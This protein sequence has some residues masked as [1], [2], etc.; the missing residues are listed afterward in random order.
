MP[1]RSC[2][3]RVINDEHNR[4]ITVGLP[5]RED[6]A[7]LRHS[8]PTVFHQTFSGEICLLIVDERGDGAVGEMAGGLAA[9]YGRVEV[10]ANQ[11]TGSR[12]ASCNRIL[13]AARGSHIAWITPGV[14][15]HPEK[16]ALQL[17]AL[18][19][20]DESAAPAICTNPF[21][22]AW[23]H[24]DADEH[25]L[26]RVAGDQRYNIAAE[27]LQ[28][29]LST[30]LGSVEVFQAAGGF[31]EN[32]DAREDHEFALRFVRS[33]GQFVNT[34]GTRALC[35]LPRAECQDLPS[36]VAL[37]NKAIWQRH[38]PVYR[39]YGWRFALEAKARH[40]W[41]TARCCR[42]NRSRYTRWMYMVRAAM[43]DLASGAAPV[44]A[45]QSALKA[46]RCAGHCVPGFVGR[47]AR[48]SAARLL[49][50]LS[51]VVA[52]TRHLGL[53][54]L[55]GWLGLAPLLDRP[56]LK[57]YF[58]RAMIAAGPDSAGFRSLYGRR[59]RN[60]GPITEA[61]AFARAR[62]AIRSGAFETAA[63][64]LERLADERGP[65]AAPRTFLKCAEAW[66]KADALEHAGA[67]L[68]RGLGYYPRDCKLLSA[69][70]EIHAMKEE[71]EAARAC[72]ERI[73]RANWACLGSWAF[74][75][76]ARVYQALG[77]HTK[78]FEVARYGLSSYPEDSK[79]AGIRD[80]VRAAMIDWRAGLIPAVTEANTQSDSVGAVERL[81]WLV[82]HDEPLKGGL[83]DIFG[84]P[85]EVC[86]D[87]NG[88]TVNRTFAARSGPGDDWPWR[89]AM[90]CGD[91]RAFL[92]DG[93]IIRITA[94][95]RPVLLAGTGPACQVHVGMP[96]RFDLLRERLEAGY[97][98]TNLGRFR[99]GRDPVQVE[100]VLGLY[101]DVARHI[102]GH[103][104][105]AVYPF[106]GNLLGAVRE[107]GFISHDVG[108]FDMA[109]LAHGVTAEAVKQEFTEI[110][111]SL[112]REG[113]QL[114]L[115]PWCAMIRRRRGDPV[116]V[117]LNYVWFNEYGELRAS[118]GW[119][120]EPTN[121]GYAFVTARQTPFEHTTI[122]V[123]ANAEDV[124][125]Q[126]Y[127]EDWRI[128]DQGFDPGRRLKRDERY[129]MNAD[130][131][132]RLAEEFPG[133]T[134]VRVETM[135]KTGRRWD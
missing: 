82:G 89:F 24:P 18:E 41:W 134:E 61:E 107:A 60:Q 125:V 92:G 4:T 5:V 120:Y 40:H 76:L 59:D 95:D 15:W 128:P 119:R 46:L 65:G 74:I 106:Y 118:Y 38:G 42:A 69:R 44:R 52:A 28:P 20:S 47:I 37:A 129:L 87:V 3:N 43:F 2:C 135:T 30:L 63:E 36:D 22:Y 99:P 33:G 45:A 83:P 71:P 97:V 29:F 96:S 25:A 122:K 70:A 67:I 32:L 86:L 90:H 12:G 23:Q 8:V 49:G 117:D 103:F 132:Q 34:A 51:V 50:P 75:R 133:Q 68:D 54:R 26:P 55:A 126:L 85:P 124:L 94:A 110:C 130:K 88:L 39:S 77:D 31:D 19:Q 79:L 121:D 16:L 48:W 17:R 93:D 62:R 98:F 102:E 57:R 109:Y 66:R 13:E 72:W 100:E 11:G 113:Y 56:G 115:E 10:L 1:T 27:Q 80:A 105:N 116:F 101:R 91:L 6:W 7:G 111:R 127:G 14:L 108:G 78:A 131:L 123:P 21:R 58:Q 35:T 53:H 104:G 114:K 64:W 73:D 9:R 112:L 81:G 84:D